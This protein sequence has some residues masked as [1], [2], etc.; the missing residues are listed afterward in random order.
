MSTTGTGTSQPAETVAIVVPA[1]NAARTIGAALESLIGQSRQDWQAV[2]VDDGSTDDTSGVVRTIAARDARISLLRTENGGA[3][4]ARNR[5]LAATRSEFVL[6]LDADDSLSPN[7]LEVM[8]GNLAGAPD[9]DVLYCGWQEIGDAGEGAVHRLQDLSDAFPV[10]ARCCPFVIHAGLARRRAVEA[11]GGFDPSLRVCEDWDLWQRIA[12]TGAR[13]APVEGVF[14]RYLRKAGSLSRDLKSMLECG[15]RVIRRGHAPDPR[16]TTGSAWK[17]GVPAHRAAGPMATYATWVLGAAL[18]QGKGEEFISPAIEQYRGCEPAPD[19][20][21]DTLFGGLKFTSDLQTRTWVD[22]WRDVSA[23]TM[24]F[25][26]GLE[27]QSRSPRLAR[28]TLRILEGR[29]A[30]HAPAEWEGEVSGLAVRLV[31]LEQ[32]RRGIGLPAGTERVKCV[33]RRSGQV[34]GAFLLAASGELSAARVR[35][36]LAEEYGVV[37]PTPRTMGSRITSRL[38]RLKQALSP[39]AAPLDAPPEVDQPAGDASQSGT[40]LAGPDRWNEV[41]ARPDPWGYGNAYETLKYRQTLEALPDR[42]YPRALELACAEGHFTVDLAPR[43]GH[44]LAT[45]IAPLALLRAAQ[46]CAHLRN[47]EFAQFDLASDQLDG[48]FD[49][50]VCSEVLY[51]LPDGDAVRALARR[52][53]EHLAPDGVVL[54]TH[55]C[56]LVDEPDETGFRWGHRFGAVGIGKLFGEDT[57]L[58]LISETRTELY[59]IQRFG[60]SDSKSASPE[61]EIQY[62]QFARSIPAKVA[63][64]ISWKGARPN[65]GFPRPPGLS[66]LA[67]HRVAGDGPA[68][69]APYRVDPAAFA[70]QMAHLSENGFTCISLADFEDAVWMGKE[71]P[72]KAVLITFDDG[73]RDVL[74]NAAPVLQRYGFPAAMFLVTD[75]VGGVSDWDE[76]FGP[77][78]LLLDEA[79]LDALSGMGFSFGAHSRRHISMQGLTPDE[80]SEEFDLMRGALERRGVSR[81]SVAYPFGE[82]DEAVARCAYAHGFRLGFSCRH[83]QWRRGD[84]AMDLPRLT[85]LGDM[86]MDAFRGLLDGA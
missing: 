21:A 34:E 42:P 60:R 65:I 40:V 84:K 51:Y 80:L 22:V 76:R 20:L 14:A 1:Y 78:A 69:L 79:G 8:L 18:G 30:R 83:G 49:L 35:G 32:P 47:V 81:L 72:D 85:V 2:V 13:F 15:L 86:D 56:L 54:L 39:P 26:E 43:V 63:D 66:I 31:D 61:A 19:L 37:E 55:A 28:R 46:R 7:H 17:D 10:T 52:L 58:R 62:R 24:S 33:V 36:V 50:I 16:V 53:A 71:P 82:S 12:R 23:P 68:G 27:R 57:G 45:D 77:P 9:A 3:G 64:Q 29:I 11:A 38:R 74:A 67:Y 6:F 41:F 5:G 70:A 73:Y 44:L 25:L 75:R 4:A 48:L 59:R